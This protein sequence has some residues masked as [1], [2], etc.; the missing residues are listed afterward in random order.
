M[1]NK[2]RIDHYLVKNNY[3]KTRTQAQ[4]L[5]KNGFVFINDNQIK[6]N[7]LLIDS[8]QE[9]KIIYFKFVSRAGY[10]LDYAIQNFKIDFKN[11]IVLDIGSSTGGFVDCAL[12]YDA[13]FVYALDVGT[14]QL[15][16]ILK[17]NS[18][19][20]SL[21]KTNLKMIC[22]E[23]FDQ[24][25]D[26]ITCDVSFISL[27][28]VFEV[29]QK[30]VNNQTI[31]IFLIKPQFELSKEILDKTKG[32]INQKKYHDLAINNVLNAAK[33]FNFKLENIIKSPIKGKK[34]LNTEYLGLFKWEK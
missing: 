8:N 11:K 22:P 30:I 18:K 10:K 23:M 5:I 15:H 4:E 16:E 2:Q 6:K 1:E 25:I 24:L 34:M 31:M 9:I 20:K 32:K 14:N 17:N 26:I 13:K 28:H 12:Q 29:I 19:V 33:T 21:E 27:K 3:C 7:N